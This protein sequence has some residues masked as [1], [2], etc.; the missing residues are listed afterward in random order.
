VV[1]V[2]LFAQKG[3]SATTT[4]ELS[5]AME[6]TNGTFYYYFPTKEDLLV[7]I[8]EESLE[9]VTHAAVEALEGVE[10][11]SPRG[12]LEALIRSHMVTMLG[13]QPLHTTML[14]EWRALSPDN[15]GN[16]TTRRDDYAK[17]VRQAIEDCQADGALASS[18]DSHIL[19]LLLL[20]MLNW[21][22]FWFDP[23]GE[24]SPGELAEAVIA[25]FMNGAVT[26]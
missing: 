5:S 26:A 9:H 21:T 13:D 11:G 6:I 2:R 17:L 18:F 14:T 7:R 23:E 24:L 3:Y 22:I 8:C 25:T 15:R 16:V 20:N 19:T 12:R 10:A 1:G 4:R